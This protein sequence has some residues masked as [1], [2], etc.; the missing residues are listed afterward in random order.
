MD[1]RALFV[2]I[3]ATALGMLLLYQSLTRLTRLQQVALAWSLVMLAL[4]LFVSNTAIVKRLVWRYSF[5]GLQQAQLDFVGSTT[6]QFTQPACETRVSALN[7]VAIVES[8]LA[9]ST[10]DRPFVKMLIGPSIHVQTAERFDD[11]TIVQGSLLPFERSLVT[12]DQLLISGTLRPT[13][14]ACKSP[15]GWSDSEVTYVIEATELTRN[16]GRIIPSFVFPSIAWLILISP[17]M[18]TLVTRKLH[19][20]KRKAFHAVGQKRSAKL[21][22]HKLSLGKGYSDLADK[23]ALY[24]QY[25][26]A[27]DLSAANLIASELQY[28]QPVDETQWLLLL[29]LF[30]T[31]GESAVCEIVTERFKL[32]E[33]T[34][35]RANI[36]LLRLIGRDARRAHET[37]APSYQKIAKLAE[38]LRRES[39]LSE[40][41]TVLIVNV[42]RETANEDDAFR[43]CKT[44]LQSHPKGLQVRKIYVRFLIKKKDFKA[45]RIELRRL[46]EHAPLTAPWSLLIAELAV[47]AE[48]DDFAVDCCNFA[49][50]IL[51][52]H[53]IHLLPRLISLFASVGKATLLED[54]LRD[55][56]VSKFS[57]FDNL[58]ELVDVAQGCG[59][60]PLASS[61]CGKLIELRPNDRELLE[62]GRFLDT[63]S[64]RFSQLRKQ[65]T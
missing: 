40:P 38:I 64:V 24:K 29:E 54:C 2:A 60:L 20:I 30:R 41:D 46:R 52:T 5:E 25:M 26:A 49:I 39:N 14:T 65:V 59:L 7:W 3:C 36:E 21:P 35:I 47:I 61:L 32:V 28:A 23:V 1:S 4:V 63:T 50:P 10:D 33:P 9:W 27:G 22:E 37:Q 55:L 57:N 51:V 43:L 17:A 53:E 18:G 34:N 42:L 56:D 31:R 16:T 11:P 6:E 62:R 48:D 8:S 13:T 19:Q 12:G 15:V 45:A 44:F 58:M